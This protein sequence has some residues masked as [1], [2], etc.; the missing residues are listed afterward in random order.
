MKKFEAES[1]SFCKLASKL[2]LVIGIL[3]TTIMLIAAINIYFITTGKDTDLHSIEIGD[4]LDQSSA[5]VT[6]NSPASSS[7]T[8]SS[9]EK[10]Y[11]ILFSDNIPLTVT[12][13]LPPQQIFLM[14]Q[15]SSGAEYRDFNYFG[16]NEPIY[17]LSG[18]LI[19][20]DLTISSM[21]MINATYLACL[22]LFANRTQHDNF[23]MY[24]SSV[25]YDDS[26]CFMSAVTPGATTASH[27]FNIIK[28]GQYYV[29]MELQSGISIQANASVLQVYYNTAGFQ[30]INCSAT[31]TCSFDV[32]NTFICNQKATT[33]FLV[34]P[35]NKIIIFYFSTSPQLNGSIYGGFI[36]IVVLG[37]LCCCFNF[38][39]FCCF[40]YCR[41]GRFNSTHKYDLLEPARTKESKNT[42]DQSF[43][44]KSN[45]DNFGPELHWPKSKLEESF[46]ST[47]DATFGGIV[48][49]HFD[50]QHLP[51]LP[52][53]AF[54]DHKSI[55]SSSTKT[56]LKSE[57]SSHLDLVDVDA[58]QSH[59]TVVETY[60][61]SDACQFHIPVSEREKPSFENYSDVLLPPQTNGEQLIGG[62]QT[63]NS[64]LTEKLLKNIK[65]AFGEV[66]MLSL[67]SSGLVYHCNQYGVTLIIP[68]G[69]VKESTTVWFGACLLSDKFKF[70]DYVPVTP[71]VWVHIDRKLDKS[72]ELYIP[73]DVIISSES[74]LQQFAILTAH[75]DCSDV[76]SFQKNYMPQLQLE[77]GFQIFKILSPHFCSN[78]VA[79]QNRVYQAISKR[80]LIARADKKI[81]SRKLLVQFIFLCQ[82]QGCRKVVED[83]C[84]KEEFR[85]ISWKPVTFTGDGQVSLSF[86]PHIV[87]GW[88]REEVGISQDYISVEDIDY[89][90]MMGCENDAEV[91]EDELER[92]KILEDLL[93]YPPRFKIEFISD[94]VV[95]KSQKVIVRF[96]QVHPPVKSTVLLEGSIDL[97]PSPSLSAT[98]IDLISNANDSLL[99]DC[100]CIIASEKDIREKWFEFGY[101]LNLTVGQLEEIEQTS[102][103]P[104]QRTR[105]VV[106]HWRD[107]NRSESWEPFAAALA[108]IGFKDLAHK[109]K[110]HFDS[111]PALESEPEVNKDHY[112]GVYCNLCKEYHL[113]PEDIQQEIPNVGFPPDMVNLTNLVAAKIPD[114]FYQFGTAVRINDGFLK[115][116]YDTYHNPMD[117]FITI[118]NRWKDNDPDT[119]TWSTVIKVLESDA[120][121]AHAV[122]QDVKKHLIAIAEAAEH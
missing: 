85:I 50:P 113:K 114:Q 43:S 67:D 54:K 48:Q 63:C 71:I 49:A 93:S 40:F 66:Y 84:D 95:E 81:G 26:Y 45:S 19:T 34:K 58:Y 29:G 96:N 110:D 121:G 94:A 15:L 88:K 57:T 101:K 116:L 16:S 73:H 30:Q 4:K 77:S 79:V 18:S 105:K 47:H 11:T 97:P 69:A 9:N 27:S 55:Q 87:P 62:K 2:M 89:Y 119:Y 118:F 28:A 68:E 25:E 44:L 13:Y 61:L 6:V 65:N 5:L 10:P 8:F 92:L 59:S 98:S 42:K 51:N 111:P 106:I 32:C 115:S 53:I 41:S 107:Q 108:K 64:S 74:N 22:Y 3:G 112:K 39:W 99:G 24:N 86:E 21:K 82:L 56:Q 109:V 76:I 20:Y 1:G 31:F 46:N 100:L 103:D 37:S 72:A 52:R 60:Q 122:A 35:S 17:L 120:I 70:G 104:I 91:T 117:R 80:Y 83:Q 23:I 33:Y 12:N 102:V 78:C 7:V 90:K 38:I 36:T 75:D 14:S